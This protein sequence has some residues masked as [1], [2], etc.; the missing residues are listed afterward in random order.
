MKRPSLF[1][2]GTLYLLAGMG[3]WLTVLICA[4]LELG[5]KMLLPGAGEETV[6]L[7]I[8]IVYYLPFVIFPLSLW[9]SK[10][11]GARQA[12]R[13]NPVR[14]VNMFRASLI[15]L[16][17]VLVG[18]NISIVWTILLQKLGLDVFV[19][20]YVRPADSTQLM[21]SAISVAVI[22]PLGEEFLFRGAMLSAWERRGPKKAVLI[23]AALFAILHGSVLG[24]P[25][26]FLCGLLLALVV[27]WSDSIYA[28]LAFHS[29]YNAGIVIIDYLS[30][31]IPVDA[32]EEAL[33][34]SD[35]LAYMGG[36][37]AVLEILVSVVLDLAIIALITRR[38]RLRYLVFRAFRNLDPRPD[39]SELMTPEKVRA[40]IRQPIPT[41]DTPMTTGE[42]LVL[43]AGI[44]TSVGL[45]VID[46]LTMLG[47]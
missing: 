29:V 18:Q 31:A 36:Y 20:E 26:Q 34:R 23:T 45:Y 1:S 43:M 3:L 4:D 33:M 27:L 32:A 41:D 40:L 6:N 7:L 47:G 8:S 30:S 25:A 5:L 10:H 22:A 38:M 19:S 15:A 24:F 35:L 11:E 9:C 21:L 37:G 17:C 46:I 44:V 39:N 14:P 16:L 2:A 28:G 42:A 12:L 13:L